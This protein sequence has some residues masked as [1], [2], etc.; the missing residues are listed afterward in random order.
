M[1]KEDSSQKERM[2]NLISREEAIRKA[3]KYAAFTV[4]S[5]MMLMSPVNSSAQMNSPRNAPMRPKRH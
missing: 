2:E 1:K 3:G 4:A 5:T